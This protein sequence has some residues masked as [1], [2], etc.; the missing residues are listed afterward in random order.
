MFESRAVV[1]FDTTAER[2]LD[3]LRGRPAVDR[4]FYAASEA[5]N[6]SLIW[7][8]LNLA[9]VAITR[10]VRRGAAIAAA[11]GVESALV[12][13]PVK[14]LFRRARP[15]ADD[16]SRPH[17]LRQPKTSSFP[18]GHATSAFCAAALQRH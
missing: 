17:R 10:D 3:T 11:L 15:T 2:V 12:N 16:N 8:G 5:G 18:S 14:M 13:G 4:F 7:H 6:H 1:G 9:Q